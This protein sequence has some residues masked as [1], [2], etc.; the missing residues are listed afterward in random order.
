MRSRKGTLADRV[1][2]LAKRKEKEKELDHVMLEGHQIEN[3]YWFEYLGSRLQCDGD[4]KA[5][6]NY[7][8]AIAQSVFSS[9]SHM[10]TDHRLPL[11]MKLRLYRCAVCSTF[12]HACE[13]WD[14]TASVKRTINGF[15]SRCLHVVTK[16]GYRET[17]TNPAFDLTLAIRRRRMRFLGH[18]LRMDGSR[19]LRRALVAYVHGGELMPAGS[20]LEDC[21]HTAFADLTRLAADRKRWARKVDALQ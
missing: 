4:D 2:Q 21:G 6:V 10:W 18:V 3:V 14:L 9:M 7:R 19:L 11:S 1:V 17:A 20:L 15:N 16:A 5:D 12:T 13:A 8:M